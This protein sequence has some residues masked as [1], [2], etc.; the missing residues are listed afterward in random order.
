MPLDSNM[1]NM[2]SLAILVQLQTFSVGGGGGGGRRIPKYLYKLC[3]YVQLQKVRFPSHWFGLK[4]SIN[5]D[6]FGLKLDIN[7]FA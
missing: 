5:F 4:T 7:S 3:R 6:F 1:P 2:V